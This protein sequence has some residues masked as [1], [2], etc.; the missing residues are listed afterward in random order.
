MPEDLLYPDKKTFKWRL[1]EFNEKSLKILLEFDYPEFISVESHDILF[2][3]FQKNNFWIRPKDDKFKAIPDDY[4]IDAK[5][6]P[7]AF[8][9]LTEE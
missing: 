6:P 2:I 5:V 1:T 9:P 8:D 3:K 4:E 7:Q